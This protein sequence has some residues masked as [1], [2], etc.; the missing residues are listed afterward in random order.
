MES[1]EKNIPNQEAEN[2]SANSELKRDEHLLK[3]GRM[4]EREKL[5]E[6]IISSGE[7]QF[8]KFGRATNIKLIIIIPPAVG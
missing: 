2:R 4:L 8:P 6:E 3:K 7:K 1:E 5:K